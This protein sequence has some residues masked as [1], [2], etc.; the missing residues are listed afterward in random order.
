M[1]HFEA[2]RGSLARA[3]PELLEK[4]DEAPRGAAVSIVSTPSGFPTALRAGISV[5]SRR[6]PRREASAQVAASIEGT[7]TTALVLGFGLGY[8]VEA[9]RERF[10]GLPVLVLEP[11]ARMFAAALEARDL[12]AILTDPRVSFLVATR[13]EEVSSRLGGLPLARPAFLRLRPALEADPAWF[14]A[15]EE[16]VRSWLL[17]RD[18][19]TNTLNRF[20]RL[21]VRNLAHNI[22]AFVDAPGIARLEGAFSGIPALVLAGGPSLDSLL[23][24]LPALSRRMLV[25][26]VNTPVKRC[27]QAG[28]EP[29]F[30]VVVDPQYWASRFLDWTRREGRAARRGITVAEPS[31]HPR[32]F[33]DPEARVYLC[34]SLFPLG[35]ALEAAVGEKGKL[36]AGGSVSTAAWDLARH[37]GASPIYAAGLDLGFPEM[38]TH[39][40]GVFTEELW[41]A[42]SGRLAPLEGSS[43]R[44][45]R[46][47]GIFPVRSASG[48]I[49]YTDR[50]MLVYK[51]WFENQLGQEPDLRSFTLS[52][53]GVA[54]DGMPFVEASR[55]LS[56]PVV[57]PKIDGILEREKRS[58]EADGGRGARLEALR[59]ALEDLRERLGELAELAAEARRKN[60][61]LGTAIEEG[62]D[63]SGILAELDSLDERILGISERSIAGFLVQSMIHRITA[64]GETKA[65]VAEVLADGRELYE[66]IE[67]SACWQRRLVDRSLAI[68]SSRS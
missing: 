64:K 35:E 1:S 60:A 32:V 10:P 18:I 65:P 30:T 3:H 66:G 33:R 27:R 8:G 52:A 15:A 23:P 50:R 5:H 42:G 49:T 36:G 43:F 38:R 68:L 59:E 48:G 11:D 34:S 57:R 24:D 9:L 16:V 51:W 22:R 12:T 25:I 61:A 17:R 6:D 20:G 39:C 63:P 14:N 55:L 7:P 58:A 19:N 46:E 54:I 47:I 29:D 13:P 41:L 53:H 37:V 2:N 56:L 26:S 28:V 62:R 31:T 4:L 67:E 21:W 45:L 44:S 40:K